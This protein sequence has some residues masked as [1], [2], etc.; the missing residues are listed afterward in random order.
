M[1]CKKSVGLYGAQWGQ[2]RFWSIFTD[3]FL[4]IRRKLGGSQIDA[5]ERF[6]YVRPLFAWYLPQTSIHTLRC[7]NSIFCV[8]WRFSAFYRCAPWNWTLCMYKKY[9]FWFVTRYLRCCVLSRESGFRRALSTYVR[10]DLFDI[11]HRKW[12][13]VEKLGCQQIDTSKCM[14]VRLA[15]FDR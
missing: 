9:I 13:Y 10:P 5:S 3:G 1:G 8:F 2:N 15:L 11:Y 12:T 4:N 14:Y 6:L 7:N